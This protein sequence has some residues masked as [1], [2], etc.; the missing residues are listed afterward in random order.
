MS[1]GRQT[2]R[3][4]RARGP[5][6]ASLA[7]TLVFL[8]WVGS[9]AGLRDVLRERAVDLLQP[10]AAN[11][12]EVVV[13]DIDR[14]ALARFGPWPWSRERMAALLG[15]VVAARPAAV[16]LD[17]LLSEPDRLSPAA[18]ARQLGAATGRAD[19]A[20][21]AGALEDG[22]G[23]LAAASREAPVSLGF[24]LEPRGGG[25]ELPAA[26]VL[27]QGDVQLPGLWAAPGLQGPPEALAEAASGLGL[28]ALDADP[29]GRIRRV[30]LL[31]LAAGTVRPGLAV[32]ALRL[33][34]GAGALVLA[35]DPMRL[36]IGAHGVRLDESATLRLRAG[37]PAR[38]AARTV[39]AAGVLDHP[40][41]AGRLSRRIVL[42]GGSAPELGGLRPAASG[43]LAPSVQLQADAVA[44]M[45]RG[46]APVRPA[47]LRHAETA[48]AALLAMGGLLACLLI[49]SLDVSYAVC[50]SRWSPYH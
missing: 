7:V 48:A 46:D 8:T 9:P 40:E 11:A 30:P 32:E 21:M 49:T 34:E 45:L 3:N 37:E 2:R 43:I 42:V 23:R 31:A 50:R 14:D 17:I 25:D 27:V 16:A 4:G 24:V 6:A 26:P 13:V 33:A 44:A 12:Q 20:A 36:L 22:D 18:L 28:L 41:E 1:A 19:I 15:A 10:P 47:A 39:P 5:W 35:S 29:D 38:W